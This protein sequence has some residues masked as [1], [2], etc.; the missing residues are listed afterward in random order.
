MP[1]AALGSALLFRRTFLRGSAQPMIMELPT[2]KV[3]SLR[4]AAITAVEQGKRFL[5]KAGT[6][7]LAICVVMWWL[8]AYPQSAPPPE[9][10]A[11]DIQAAQP[12][13]DPDQAAAWRAEAARLTERHAQANSFAG[14]IGRTVQPVFAPLDYDWQVTV[15]IL[16]SFIAREVFVST[17]AVLLVGDD[18]P[19]LEDQSVIATI[20]SATRDDGSPVFKTAS[21]ASLLVFFVLAMQCLPTLVLTRKETGSG[22]WALFQLLYMTGLAYL[23]G[24][25]T[26][27]GLLLLGVT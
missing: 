2:Y 7:I 13:A 24:W 1:G 21:S 3:P 6:I 16:T 26:Y 18:D 20:A 12:G 4:T 27:R 11:L 9:A 17:L 23:C 5:R 22:R 8:S 15:G 14:R 10:V 25:L 19:D